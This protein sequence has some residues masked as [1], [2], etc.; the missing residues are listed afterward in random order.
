LPLTPAPGQP[1]RNGGTYGTTL[2]LNLPDIERLNN[3]NLH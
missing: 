1:Y 3:P 2:C